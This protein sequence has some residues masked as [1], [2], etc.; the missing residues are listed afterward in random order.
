M[1]PWGHSSRTSDMLPTGFKGSKAA[2]PFI[3]GGWY[4][5]FTRQRICQ[6]KILLVSRFAVLTFGTTIYI[7]MTLALR[8]YLTGEVFFVCCYVSSSLKLG[9]MG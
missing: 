4:D 2:Q 8:A 6:S 7:M 3:Q 5:S 1:N 9:H